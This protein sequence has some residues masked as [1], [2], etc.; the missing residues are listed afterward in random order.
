M[1][2]VEKSK[3]DIAEIVALGAIDSSLFYSTFFS[4]TARQAAPPMHKEIDGVLDGTDRLV[5]ILMSRGW[6]KTSKLRMY[7]GKR[8]AYNISKTILFVGASEK[9]T[10]RSI[11][12]IRNQIDRNKLFAETFQLSAGTPWTDEEAEIRH[13]IDGNSI[14]ITGVGVTSSSGRGINFDDFRPDLIIL[15]DVMN[16]ENSAS[17]EAREKIINLVFGAF[18]ES[19][20]PRSEAPFAKMVMLNTPQDYNDISQMAFKDKTFVSRRFGCW[21]RETENAPL[22]ARVSAWPER[23]PTEE[24]QDEYRAAAARNRLSIFIR[25][26]ECKLT[27]PEN[28]A[29]KNEW[30]RYFGEGEDHS[31]PAL[32]E[33]WTILVIDPVPPPT[34]IA[35]QKGIVDSDYEAMSVLGKYKGKIFVL[36]TI[37][38]RGHDPNWTANE[39]F[40][41][42]QK[43]RIRKALVESVVYQR[44]L[45]WYLREQMRKQ[46][47]YILLEPFGEGDKRSK[48]QKILDGITG[49]ASNNQLYVRRDQ[50]DLISQYTNF[51]VV[52]KIGHDDVLETVAVGCT[53][54][55]NGGM[56]VSDTVLELEEDQYQDLDDY[57]GAP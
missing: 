11:R 5:N 10:R 22:E 54:L 50:H 40:R 24:L 6:A 26:K 41:L 32:E 27:S 36:D 39:F 14:W 53:E 30:L 9:H 44:T 48:T 1:T 38:H 31:E 37:S 18:M 51:S 42:A 57:R 52:R 23:I 20:A 17:K 19:L 12:W 47:R 45:V 34:E 35:L 16:D 46:G 4:K 33:M 8:I 21:T 7:A 56:N 3:V 55:L 43:W 2:I 28:S 15:D 29:F 25:E 49:V 13:G